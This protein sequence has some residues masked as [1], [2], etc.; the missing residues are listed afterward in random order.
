MYG[1]FATLR[2]RAQE[3]VRGIVEGEAAKPAARGSIGQKV[4]DYYKSFIDEGRVESLG[5][6]PLAGELKTIDA[7]SSRA[8]LPAAFGRAARVGAR[9]PFTVGVGQDPRKSDVYTVLIGQSGLGMPDRDYYLR[10][11]EKFLAIRNAYTGY[12]ARLFELAQRPDPAGAAGRVLALETTLAKAQWDRARSRD[13]DAAYNK[14]TR[15]ELQSAMPNFDWNTYFTQVGAPRVADVIVRQPDYLTAVDAALAAT[16]IATWKDYLAFGMLNAFAEELS[17]PFATAHFEFNGKVIGGRQEMQPRWKR[18]VSAVEEALGEPV[19]KLYVERYFKPEA[20]ARMDA[21]IRNLLA[22]FK[23]GIDELE[24]MSPET[25][26]EAQAKLAKYAM[27]I[28]Y[29]DRW[30][31]YSALEVQAGDLVG[32]VMRSRGLQYSENWGRLGQPV[33]RWRWGFTPQTVNASYSP[34]NNE[35]TFPAGILQPPFF[36][37]DAD[38]AI[39]YGAIGAVIGHEISHGFDDQGRKS[40]GDGNLRDWWTAE[41][42]KKFEERA[43]KLGTQFESYSPV[44]GMKINGRQTMGENIGDL[45]GVA[46]AFRAYKMSLNGKPAPVIGG[47]TGEQRF[48]LGYAQIWRFKSR[49]EA[50]RNQLLTDSHSPGM[51]RAFVPLTNIDAF[52]EAF[53]LKPGDKLYRPPAERVKIW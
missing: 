48:F 24:W 49:D 22:A 30:R 43:A 51:F 20:K 52:Y 35:I 18:A 37:L 6:Q 46:V 26:R 34:P 7:I 19:G 31:D 23:V 36:N 40:D 16:P 29:P 1:T 11:D 47:F 42:A 32:N 44:A 25:K 33:E 17:S 53:D 21:L 38:D 13:R 39:N 15:A 12:I 8:G 14:R 50:L 27:K 4:G 41:D 5:V 10:S 45:S 3:A 28:A 2:D 9:V